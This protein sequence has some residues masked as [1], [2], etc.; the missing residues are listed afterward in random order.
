MAATQARNSLPAD[1]KRR[2]I[3]LILETLVVSG[4]LSRAD[5]ARSTAISGTSISKLTADLLRAGVLDEDT[6]A[7]DGSAGRPARRLRVRQQRRYVVG[8]D[9]GASN[10]RL[11][12]VDFAGAVVAQETFATDRTAT[13][14]ML[15]AAI[16]ACLDRMLDVQTLPRDAVRA[17]GLGVPCSIDPTSGRLWRTEILPALDSIAIHDLTERSFPF[18]VV[19]KRDTNLAVIGEH[20]FGVARAYQDVFL[21]SVG[22]GIGGGVLLRGALYEGVQGNAGD[23]GYLRLPVIDGE[24]ETLPI[25]E[26]IAAGPA[27]IADARARGHAYGTPPD[28]FDAARRGDAGARALVDEAARY[29]ARALAAAVSLYD[30]ALLV[31]TG[32]LG[33]PD[34]PLLGPMDRWLDRLCARRPPLV[35]GTLSQMAVA[36]GGVAVALDVVHERAVRAGLD[37]EPAARHLALTIGGALGDLERRVHDGER[38]R[39]HERW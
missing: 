38:P 1:I 18:P 31:L 7:Q 23:I 13:A 26:D 32:G 5:L 22:T 12:L 3:A 34:S 30:P 25:L 35:A 20:A 27:L 16:D 24:A 37:A 39:P 19:S 8:A 11:L 6:G 4:P 9:L 33:Q 17:M 36:R 28:I 29:L 10:T 15:L 21:L 14:P 2:N